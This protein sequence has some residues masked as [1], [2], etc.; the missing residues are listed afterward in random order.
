MNRK[1]MKEADTAPQAATSPQG[2][3]TPPRNPRHQRFADLVLQGLSQTEAYLR[4]CGDAKPLSRVT[5]KDGGTR[6][7][8]RADVMAYMDA[9]RR[10]A[11][12]DAV[13]SL[14][15]KRGFLARVLRVPLTVID[16]HDPADPNR[17]LVR[18]VK[19]RFLAKRERGETVE[20]I[21]EDMEKLDPL[22]AIELDNKLAG[23]D[24]KGAED[25]VRKLAEI[26]A[27]LGNGST[28]PEEGM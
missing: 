28:L 13:L 19:R 4:A 21:V 12:T 14:A 5:A 23:T 6:L 10:R 24:N 15:E 17:D 3:I 26:L 1:A 8:R 2:A 7:I 16:P 18:K 22:K 27:G 9:A 11:T 25:S 20:Y